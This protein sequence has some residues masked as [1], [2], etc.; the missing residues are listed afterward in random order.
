MATG[1]PGGIEIARNLLPRVW[2]GAH[3]ERKVVAGM[4]T[5]GIERT[6]FL[7]EEV[8][9]SLEGGR[10]RTVVLTLEGGMEV[11]VRL[12]EEGRC[13]PRKSW[14]QE[15]VVNVEE[16]EKEKEKNACEEADKEMAKETEK[17]VITEEPRAESRGTNESSTDDYNDIGS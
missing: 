6:D 12:G 16:K 17:S 5:R 11:W 7:A 8:Q 10:V 2:I 15:V 13:E 9:G 14:V 4:L 1:L 3:D